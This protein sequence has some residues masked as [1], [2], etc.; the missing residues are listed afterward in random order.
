[1]HVRGVAGRDGGGAQLDGGGQGVAGGLHGPGGLGQ[2]GDRLQA[3]VLSARVVLADRAGDE[4]GVARGDGR[5]GGAGEDEDALAG[6]RV[7]VRVGVLEPEAAGRA[8]GLDGGDDAGDVLHLVSGERGYPGG[9]LD[10]VDPHAG[11]FGARGLG[12]GASSPAAS[13]TAMTAPVDAERLCGVGR[14]V[15]TE[16]S[17]W[18]GGTCMG[19]VREGAVLWCD[20]PKTYGA[21]RLN[22]LRASISCV[23]MAVVKGPWVYGGRRIREPGGRGRNTS[24]AWAVRH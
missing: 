8:E 24:Q 20:P 18:S 4:Y 12:G 19:V 16:A 7:V 3:R 10:V 11:A 13:A 23:S 9:A 15:G 17:G 21:F 2:L 14:L 5:G 6:G 1:M 22:D